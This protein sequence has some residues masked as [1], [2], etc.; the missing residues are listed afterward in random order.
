MVRR[1][2]YWETNSDGN[3]LDSREEWSGE[4]LLIQFDDRQAGLA[5]RQA[6]TADR[7]TFGKEEEAKMDG[8]NGNIY[9]P[10]LH[11]SLNVDLHLDILFIWQSLW[12]KWI[13]NWD[14]V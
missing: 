10:V 12:V 6:D 1:Y 9:S 3:C 7:K 14:H 5:E 13:S 2:D 4:H 11:S 8:P